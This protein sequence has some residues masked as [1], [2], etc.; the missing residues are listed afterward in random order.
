M[1]CIWMQS[2]Q[3]TETNSDVAVKYSES[4]GVQSV[5][6]TVLYMSMNG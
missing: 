4:Y 1:L 6:N 3:S 2:V 5:K